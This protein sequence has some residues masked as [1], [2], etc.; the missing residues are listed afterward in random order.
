[1]S[2]DPAFKKPAAGV[3]VKLDGDISVNRCIHGCKDMRFLE[4]IVII[5]LWF[6][7]FC[8]KCKHQH[9]LNNAFPV[10][11]KIFPAAAHWFVALI[12]VFVN[13]RQVYISVV[14]KIICRSISYLCKTKTKK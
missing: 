7:P 10:D 5:L 6:S 11:C 12:A 14:E 4:E 1:M 2:G 8:C 13:C 3:V 9:G